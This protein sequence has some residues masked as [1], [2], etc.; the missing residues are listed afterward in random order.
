MFAAAF[1]DV[2]RLAYRVRRV[3]RLMRRHPWRSSLIIVGTWLIVS[4]VWGNVLIANAAADAEG[5]VHLPFLSPLELSDTAGVPM[6]QYVVLPYDHG[7][8]PWAIDDWFFSRIIDPI[9]IIHVTWINWMLWLLHFLLSFEWV[10]W[11][12]AP[13]EAVFQVFSPLITSIG[14]IPTGLGLA[15]VILSIHVLRGRAASGVADASISILAAAM[16]LGLASNPISMLTADDGAF[17]T[18]QKFGG[19]F[20][21]AIATDDTEMLSN[22]PTGEEASQ[23]IA[24]TLAGQIIDVWVRIPAQEIMYGHP[25][26]GECLELFNGAMTARENPLDGNDSKVRDLIKMC[27]EEAG[28]NAENPSWGSL[29]STMSMIGGAF[30]LLGLNFVVGIL[31]FLAVLFIAFNI[32]KFIGSA[33]LGIVPGVAR[34]SMV[35]SAM[36]IATGM[37]LTVVVVCTISISLRLVT[38]VVL[39]LAEKGWAVIA[40]MWVVNTITLIMLGALIVIAFKMKKSGK[41]LADRIKKREPR[42]ISPVRQQM[43][44]TMQR[45]AAGSNMMKVAGSTLRG[46]VLSGAA[47]A[48]GLVVKSAIKKRHAATGHDSTTA[49]TNTTPSTADASTTPSDTS[50]ATTPSAAAGVGA[51]TSTHTDGAQESTTA[52]NASP[53]PPGHIVPDGTGGH[54]FVRDPQPLVRPRRAPRPTAAPSATPLT[55]PPAAGKKTKGAAKVAAAAPAVAQAIANPGSMPAIAP[56]ATAVMSAGKQER[57]RSLQSNLNRIRDG[58]EPQNWSGWNELSIREKRTHAREMERELLRLRQS[59]GSSALPPQPQ[60]GGPKPNNAL[61]DRLKAAVSRQEKVPSFRA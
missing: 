55:P 27:D 58:L 1:T 59:Q 25:L 5:Y 37:L 6:Y 47:A 39:M 32:Y 46:G 29:M 38:S 28:H 60:W 52:E 30:I 48:G 26:S 15:A 20:A 22:P 24:D 49:G 3:T 40:Q 2:I 21:A 12:A 53:R 17:N 50:T 16:L 9:W 61:R 42:Q 8:I 13:L 14:W 35:Q 23:A 56:V 41:S 54:V 7:G 31:L 18:V 43:G 10:A 57:A 11:I 19:S 33:A 45:Y 44:R 34:R 4:I 51:Q 36:S